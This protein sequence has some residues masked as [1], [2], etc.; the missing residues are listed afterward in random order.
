MSLSD[1]GY[2]IFLRGIYLTSKRPSCDIPRWFLICNVVPFYLTLNN[3]NMFL[4]NFEPKK[5]NRRRYGWY[6]GKG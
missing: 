4:R 5:K 2:T 1:F 6:S 3:F